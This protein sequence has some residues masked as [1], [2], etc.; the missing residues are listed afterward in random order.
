QSICMGSDVTFSVIA[1]GSSLTYQWRK[2]GVDII[3]ATSPT[4][5]VRKA[6]A[7]DAGNYEVVVVDANGC[8]VTSM[9]A[10]LSV[11]PLLIA[12]ASAGSILCH[13]GTTTI[14]ASASGGQ[15]PYQ[16][17]TNGTVFQSSA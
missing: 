17:S 6:G 7:V 16:Y 4:Y 2:A 11:N 1:S 8:S 12:G 13:G 3:G 15:S 14:T 10:A 9:P 5:T